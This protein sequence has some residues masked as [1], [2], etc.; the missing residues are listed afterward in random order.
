MTSYTLSPVWGAGAQLFDNSGNVLTGGKIETYEAGTT[1]NA[2]TYTNPIGSTANSNPII[3]DASGRLS[4]EIWLLVGTSYKFVLKDANN[5]LI[6]TYDNIPSTPQPPIVNDASSISYEQGYTVTAGAFTVGATYLIT[7]VGTTNFVAIGAA[8]NAIGVLFT[9]T[10]VGS[11]N[12]TA[13]YSRTVQAK[14]RDTVNVKD[15]GAVGDGVTDDATAIQ[16][17]INA[18]ASVGGGVVNLTEGTFIIGATLLMKDGVSLQGEGRAVTIIKLKNSANC[19]L[20]DKDPA[21]TG[22]NMGLFDLTFNGNQANNTQGGV[23]L[24]GPDGQRGFA[25]VVERIVVT[26]CR[27]ADYSSGV[28]SALLFAGNTFGQFKDIDVINNDYCN[29]AMWVASADAQFNN[30]Y[31]GT[32]CRLSNQGLSSI[33]CG[34]FITGGGNNFIGCYL[35]GTQTGPQLYLDGASCGWNRFV[36]C[37]M[38]NAGS[39]AIRLGLGVFENIFS[40]CRIGNSS[41][42]DGGTY[43]TVY[44]DTSDGNNLFNG[45]IFYTYLSS[46][47]PRYA[48]FESG[49]TTGGNHIVG[50]EFSGTWLTG[51][52]GRSNSSTTQ[53]VACRGFNTSDFINVYSSTAVRVG[54]KEDNT[55][56]PGVRL[57]SDGLATLARNSNYPLLVRRL[58]NDGDL[59]AWLN[60]AGTFVA[61]V[62][63]SGAN[64]V[65]GTSSDYRL[66]Q[67]V[68]PMT[69][70]LEKNDLLNPVTFTWKQDKKQGQGFIAHE[71]QELFPEAV[72]GQKDGLD[73]EGKPKYQNVDTSFL[74]AHLV[75]CIKELKSEINV[76]KGS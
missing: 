50:C 40:A 34:M 55:A 29:V 5:V 49:G 18:M 15:F 14:L 43:D 56:N 16:A 36:G 64:I 72:V 75:A 3:A 12:G 26:N 7:S 73:E 21:A 62:S 54:A 8:A 37:I 74:I 35:G 32:N 22:L 10:G 71:L 25:W 57:F 41:Y 20:I 28:K 67:D 45:C 30:I 17:A 60:S 63:V 51:V 13:Q 23:L 33:N 47:K 6:A 9:A 4:N 38:D 66:K 76:L 61:S 2:V 19:N 24:I 39:D 44:S 52:D 11:G 65:Y 31:L 42:S 48:Y 68:A 46:N 70:A 27:N 1:T 69:S 59:V 58:T 53:I